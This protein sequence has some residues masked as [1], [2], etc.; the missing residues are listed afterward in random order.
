MPATQREITCQKI[1]DP[2]ARQQMFDRA[3]E[4]FRKH[5]TIRRA[6]KSAKLA[7]RTLREWLYKDPIMAAAFKDADLDVSDEVEELAFKQAKEGAY[8]ITL[9]LLES[10]NKRYMQK[11]IVEIQQTL[12]LDN[13]VQKMRQ[14]AIA[15][16]TLAPTIKAALQLALEAIP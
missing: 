7:P 2:V 1:H 4:G 14:I 5:K 12:N 8:N 11:S 16:P 3:L 10:R 6:A 15:Q 13:V 9:R